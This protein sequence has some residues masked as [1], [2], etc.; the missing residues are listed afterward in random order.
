MNIKI[1]L[2]LY[3]V[4]CQHSFSLNFEYN[5]F[6]YHWWKFP[7][8]IPDISIPFFHI[9][10]HLYYEPPT[11]I[12]PFVPTNPQ[13]L[14]PDQYCEWKSLTSINGK[15]KDNFRLLE[16]LCSRW[17]EMVDSVPLIGGRIF[18]FNLTFN[19]GILE[20]LHWSCTPHFVRW[21]RTQS[22]Y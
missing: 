15:R 21:L 9:A 19:I 1:W 7:F 20:A 2:M 12:E 22:W 13:F 18:I 6:F 14:L 11:S 17:F 10:V 4:F 8:Y 16:V 5:D 3:F